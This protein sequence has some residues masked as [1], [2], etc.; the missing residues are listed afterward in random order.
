L[1]NRRGERAACRIDI[2]SIGQ[3]MALDRIDSESRP[4]LSRSLNLPQSISLNIAN[5][6][7]VGPFITIPAML[8]AMHGPQALLAWLV[9]GLLV[10][11][12]GLVWSELGAALPG[13]G[14]SY[15]FLREIYGRLHPTWGRL[16]PFLFSSGSF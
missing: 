1:N 7:G 5:M 6:V 13:S 14:G 12:D 15:H 16:V 8:S 4:G 3:F 11:C 2:T 9:A 10:L